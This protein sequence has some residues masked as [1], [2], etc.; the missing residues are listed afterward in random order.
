MATYSGLSYLR[1]PPERGF[2]LLPEQRPYAAL[3]GNLNT[4]WVAGSPA[5]PSRRYLEMG[6]T[7][8]RDIASIRVYPLN[9]AIGL[10]RTVVVSWN[11]AHQ[12][13]FKLKAGW[14]TLPLDAHQ[15]SKLRIRVVGTSGFFGGS[16]GITEM[17]VPGLTV[18]ESL[19]LPTGL[20]ARARTF[21][22]NANPIS[23]LLSRTTADFPGRAGDEVQ[24]PEAEN[25][26]DMVDAERGIERDVTL[27]AA[28]GFLVGGWASVS[29]TVSDSSIDRLTGMPRGWSFTSSSRFEGIAANRASSAFDGTLRPWI[30]DSLPGKPDPWIEWASPRPV[31]VSRLRLTPGPAGYGFPT[32]VT[33]TTPRY[34][35]VLPVDLNTG[36]VA[37]G[38]RVR[39]RSMRITMQSIAIVG[40]A[41][42]KGRLLRA[43]AVR[44]IDIRV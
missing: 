31:T 36:D 21:N 24:D 39:T 28:R 42:A 6:F 13:T 37:L 18:H 1:A 30:G 7:S 15:V 11:G 12:H 40:G 29:P 22:P 9:D 14:N 38:R 43:V 5:T 34:S 35:R 3:D 44:E 4:S 19:R 32:R 17:E 25:P 26:I 8:P 20:A 16:G 41:A 23:V 2:S 33:V 10:T 27:P